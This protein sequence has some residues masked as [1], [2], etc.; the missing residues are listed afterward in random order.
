MLYS[1]QIQHSSSQPSLH[2]I[3]L[4]FSLSVGADQQRFLEQFA[5]FLPLFKI[6]PVHSHLLSVLQLL[7]NV[8][9]EF[10]EVG[11]NLSC[12]CSVLP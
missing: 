4:S 8:K 11:L 12:Y 9:E 1:S 5:A 3:Y 2:F 7:F 10:N 6:L